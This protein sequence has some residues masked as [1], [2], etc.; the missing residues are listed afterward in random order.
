MLTFAIK[1]KPNQQKDN[2]KDWA[3]SYSCNF[4][5]AGVV[6]YTDVGQGVAFL[7]KETIQRMCPSFIGKPVLIDHY[8][9]TPAT[10]EKKAV[11]YVTRVWFNE[12]DGWF[13]CEFLVTDDKAKEL[14]AKG[15]SVSCA[16]DVLS[17]SKGGEWHNI[18]YDEELTDCAFTHLALVSSPRYEACKIYMNSKGMGTMKHNDERQ[19]MEIEQEEEKA[20]LNAK[21]CPKCEEADLKKTT[22]NN[23]GKYLVCPACGYTEQV[24]KQNAPAPKEPWE[25]IDNS[26]ADETDDTEFEILEEARYF[27]AKECPSCGS[28]DTKK[29][30]GPETF[31]CVDCGH[32]FNSKKENIIMFGL[33]K[34]KKK[35][36]NKLD[37]SKAFV[38]VDGE[39]IS[40]KTLLNSMETVEATEVAT[41][42]TIVVDGQEVA[43]ADLVKSFQN[44][45]KKNTPKDTPDDMENADD[46]EE[47]E[48][49]DDDDKENESEE[50]HEEP[51]KDKKKKDALMTAKPKKSPVKNKDKK[52]DGDEEEAEEETKEH[53]KK[54]DSKT[55]GKHFSRIDNARENGEAAEETDE[56]PSTMAGKVARGNQR[57]S[58]TADK[59]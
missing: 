27:N 4:L 56:F 59:K 12:Q 10:F 37:A 32:K 14:I 52:E 55:N 29:V 44:K 17:T 47:K 28:K 50:E 46:D 7:K 58:S 13:W 39:R 25:I 33:E 23:G 3:K 36:N 53:D 43:V 41:D 22:G 48:N 38:V 51:K 19:T 9:V 45:K 15:Y 8:D 31:K 26:E 42:E 54:K 57:Y 11:G 6:S 5:E 20:K 2:A 21:R 30:S 18:K 1:T 34:K 49:D 40:V 16:F 35:E 24:F